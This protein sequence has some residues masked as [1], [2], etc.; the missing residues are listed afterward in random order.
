MGAYNKRLYYTLRSSTIRHPTSAKM[1][2]MQK[3]KKYFPYFYIL[4]LIFSFFYVRDVLKEG[5]LREYDSN[6]EETKKVLDVNVTLIANGKTFTAKLRSNDTI[7]DLFEDL[8]DDNNFYY[9]KTDYT[10]GTEIE[11]VNGEKAPAGY[12]WEVFL[13]ED[14]VTNNIGDIYLE[15]EQAY[16][17]KLLEQ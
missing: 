17:I 15:D 7:F 9:E 14:V 6:V 8:R 10:Y 12:K 11:M 5:E 1:N 3:A 4:F 16:V 2:Y 13:N